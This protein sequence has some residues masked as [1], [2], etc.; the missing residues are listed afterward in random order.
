MAVY[1]AYHKDPRNRLTHFVGVPA[2][3]V[4]ILIPMGWLR[5]SIAG[6]EISL[7]MVFAGVVLVYYY[8]LDVALGIALTAFVALIL[9][10][11]EAI[12]TQLTV[13]EGAWLFAITF[14][15]GWVLQ[16]VGHALEGR[17]PA[18]VD[19]FWQ[20]LVAPVFLM[21]EV[22]FAVGCKQDVKRKLDELSRQ[23]PKTIAP[24]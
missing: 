12:A 15:G 9:W 24:H 6:F 10:L 13:A 14:L 7:A 20:V 3:I 22:F 4:A 11:T 18:L 23:G 8:L 16:L 19:N 1:A 2:I 17:R 5:F 21:A